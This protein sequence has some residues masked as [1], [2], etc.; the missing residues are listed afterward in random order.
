MIKYI[1]AYRVGVYLLSGREAN[2]TNYPT[3]TTQFQQL[4][5]WTDKA[6]TR[7]IYNMVIGW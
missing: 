4:G 1:L 5:C 3:Y 6:V 7:S 2:Y